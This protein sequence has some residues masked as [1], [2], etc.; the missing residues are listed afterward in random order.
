MSLA[1]ASH[2]PT[3]IP[4]RS[5]WRRS[6]VATLFGVLFAA[7]C[8]SGPPS[9][10]ITDPWAP[11]NRPIFGVNVDIDDHAMGPVARGWKKITPGPVRRSVANVESNLEFPVRFL[12]HLGQAQLLAAGSELG[13]FLLNSTLG[14]G[15]IFDP[16]T[17]AGLPVRQTDFGTMFARWG[18]PPGPYIVVPLLGPS[19][20]R[21]TIGGILTIP[22]DPLFWAGFYLVP[23]DVLFAINNRALADDAIEQAKASSLD[24][25]VSTRDAY[26]QR[27]NRELRGE[28]VTQPRDGE[29]DAAFPP[30]FYDLPEERAATPPSTF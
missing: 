25:Y 16:A 20:P 9:Q 19:T 3:R 14:F 22:L 17:E 10:E 18:I 24:F 12:A 5:G 27:R 11:V 29:I 6:A 23:I 28:Y 13:R 7:G 4:A 15:G 21:E 2:L 30:D 1:C 26:I 8:A